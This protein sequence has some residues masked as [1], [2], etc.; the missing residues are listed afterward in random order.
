MPERQREWLNDADSAEMVRKSRASPPYSRTLCKRL[1][2]LDHRTA[3]GK[4]IRALEQELSRHLGGN[5]SITQKLLVTRLAKVSLRI[6]LL[7]AKIANSDGS[8]FDIKVL[9]GLSSQFR[10]MIA[11]LGMEAAPSAPL[12]LSEALRAG[13]GHAD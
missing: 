11:Q 8:E 3:E 10:L 9:G 12:S 2:H 5:L 1:D 4:F 13:S 7:D 6:E